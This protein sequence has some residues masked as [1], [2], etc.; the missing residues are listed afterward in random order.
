MKA[1]VMVFG[2]GEARLDWRD[3]PD[4][5]PGQGEILIRVR[6]T[7]VNRADIYQRQG[8]YPVAKG[9]DAHSPVIAGLEA[10]GEVVE[11]VE[12]DSTVD[13]ESLKRW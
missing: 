3:V 5:V 12:E 4:P 10:A 13:L 8:A 9:E 2:Q 11:A 1:M 7:A 6:A